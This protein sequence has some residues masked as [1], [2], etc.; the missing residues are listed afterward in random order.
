[1]KDNG[2]II[3]M[4]GVALVIC[5]SFGFKKVESSNLEI[6]KALKGIQE[7]ISNQKINVL[8]G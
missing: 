1:M 6:A 2:L 5:L 7:L 8:H 4:I 3:G